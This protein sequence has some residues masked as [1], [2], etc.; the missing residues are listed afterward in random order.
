MS[1]QHVRSGVYFFQA[2]SGEIKIGYS[3][4]IIRRLGLVN[5][6]SPSRVTCLAYLE[7]EGEK[8]EGE[9]HEQFRE[10]RVH[11]EWFA[12]H[13]TLL[14]F[15]RENATPYVKPVKKPKSA[16]V[17]GGEPG[18]L[19]RKPRTYFRARRKRGSW[20]VWAPD[21]L[22]PHVRDRYAVEMTGEHTQTGF[23][24]FS[25]CCTQCQAMVNPSTRYPMNHIEEHE[26]ESHGLP[27][28]AFAY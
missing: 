2:A 19:P 9:L 15:I 14:A 22:P 25:V 7:G 5:W 21:K 16:A 1:N 23:R 6:S 8:R 27:K 28:D 24:I 20:R 4:D 26:R 18:A 17:P 10:H 3:A 13:E 12:P 11:L